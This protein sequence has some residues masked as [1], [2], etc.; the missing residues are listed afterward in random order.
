MFAALIFA[1]VVPISQHAV[2][3]GY[4]TAMDRSPLNDCRL[5]SEALQQSGWA[6]SDIA[7]ID[8]SKEGGSLNFLESEVA[9]T[10]N[11][12]LL[13]YVSGKFVSDPP[14]LDARLAEGWNWDRLMAT[15]AK[16]GAITFV[17]DTGY[18]NLAYG[19]FAPNVRGLILDY[20]WRDASQARRT[21]TVMHR[22]TRMEEVGILTYII[23]REWPF[24]TDLL[25]LAY[26]VNKIK[27]SASM[28]ALWAETP[29]V[30]AYGRGILNP[31][32]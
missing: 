15:L 14:R 26:R 17:P 13:V 6:S 4:P 27:D 11:D 18:S 24:S 20:S 32:N 10:K 9:K 8:G 25:N 1:A 19:R 21:T 12:N 2:L 30:K 16:G 23:A 28:A 22:G 31:L 3:I 7:V 5:M 29:R